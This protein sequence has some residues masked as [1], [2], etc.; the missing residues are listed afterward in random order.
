[1]AGAIAGT[2]ILKINGKQDHLDTVTLTINNECN[3]HCEHCY[4]QYVSSK[5]VIG[6]DTLDGVLGNRFRHLSIVGKEPLVN[7]LSI[8]KLCEIVERCK[9]AN[10]TISFVTNGMN[11]SS[12]P[13]DIIPLLDY[14][15]VSFDGGA[16]SYEKYRKGSLSKILDG[17]QYCLAHGLKEVNALHTICNQTIDNLTDCIDLKRF[18]PFSN[19]LFTPYLVTRNQGKNTVSPIPLTDIIQQLE[20]N[21]ELN[22]TEGTSVLIDNYHIE[23]GNISVSE[24]DGL[25][26]KVK[27]A[28]KF[29]VFK[30][31]PIF[32]GIIRVTYDGYILS[33][34]QS[35]HT[36]QYHT[37]PT[38][39][40]K[41]D[42]NEAF[43]KLLKLERAYHGD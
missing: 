41:T 14:I 3:M 2:A 27:H 23:Q 15:D 20:N 11:L 8:S 13:T 31:D 25:L 19:I 32:Y 40:R 26:N 22:N 6:D 33:P 39:N 9:E 34:R 24:L 10:R 4:L 17:I 28:D 18:V 1:M 12:L 36:T 5:G 29:R 16:L 21:D 43:Q 37:A 7:A 38:V 35:L 42:L 30:D